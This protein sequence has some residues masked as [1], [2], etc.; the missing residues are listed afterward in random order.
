MRRLRSFSAIIGL[1]AA[2]L[3]LPTNADDINEESW[4]FQLTP[5]VWMAG[6]AGD[7]RPLENAPTVST[8]R[9]FSS[10]LDDL[11]GAFFMTGTAR[12][13]RW[14]LFG[15]I[16]W[17]SLS[18]AST[19]PFGIVAN[20]KLRQRF[21]TAAA[22]YQVMTTPTQQL[23]L[24]A[25][26][27]TWQIDTDINIPALGIDVAKTKQWVDPIVAARLRSHWAP[28]WSTLLHA[29]IGGL[30]MSNKNTWQVVATLNYQFSDTLYLS[31][32]YRHLSVKRDETDSLIDIEMGGPLA[33]ITWRF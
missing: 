16:S 15:D 4:R 27:R 10:I 26:A 20:S 30:E 33:G 18:Q 11:D 13:D 8:S 14:V 19:L 17:A 24:L 32:G 23:D 9:S 6:L 22:G 12:Q 2:G 21:I 1:I 29:D 7:V 28:N 3:A 31:G 25:G 5:Y